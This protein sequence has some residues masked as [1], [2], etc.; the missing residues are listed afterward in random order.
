MKGEILAT[1]H[2]IVIDGQQID[3]WFNFRESTIQAFIDGVLVMSSH[4]SS[5]HKSFNYINILEVATTLLQNHELKKLHLE[6]L[7][8]LE[9]SENEPNN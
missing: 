5:T 1:N 2:T 7:Q 3:L 9:E 4:Y 6:K 8:Q